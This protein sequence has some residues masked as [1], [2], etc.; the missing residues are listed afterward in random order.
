MFTLLILL[1]LEK[2]LVIAYAGISLMFI[3]SG[4]SLCVC[5]D[6]GTAD[7]WDHMGEVLLGFLLSVQRKIGFFLYI[8]TRNP[9]ASAVAPPL[10]SL[11]WAG[12]SA[13]AWW[14]AAHAVVPHTHI[15]Q[16]W[17]SPG[18]R[19]SFHDHPAYSLHTIVSGLCILIFIVW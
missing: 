8:I 9:L 14:A 19:S 5:L 3:A 17:C 1:L 7:S 16:L 11:L 12:V 2:L 15:K 10:S 6:Y 13:S 18:S 4:Y